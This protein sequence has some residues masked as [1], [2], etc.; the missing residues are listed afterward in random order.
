MKFTVLENFLPTESYEGSLFTDN[1]GDYIA[2]LTSDIPF[3]LQLCGKFIQCNSKM[4]LIKETKVERDS[5]SDT[6]IYKAYF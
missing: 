1:H 5:E 3:N 2:F 6:L 4:Y